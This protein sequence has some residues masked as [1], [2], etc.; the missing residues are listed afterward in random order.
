[1]YKNYLWENMKKYQHNPEIF[2]SHFAGQGL[3]AFRGRRVQYGGSAI[4]GLLK[5][6]AVPLLSNITELVAPLVVKGAEKITHKAMKKVAPRNK[7]LQRMVADSVGQAAALG[8][9]TAHKAVKRQSGAGH[10]KSK[11]QC[12]D[13]FAKCHS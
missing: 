6:V 8:I 2:R 1:L 9:N 3:P 13:I 5:R 10:Y 12:T 7:R 11:R 4:A